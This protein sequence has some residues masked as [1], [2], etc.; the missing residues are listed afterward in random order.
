MILHPAREKS[1]SSK[2]QS[3]QDT[4]V[5]KICV[6]TLLENKVIGGLASSDG[7]SF[8]AFQGVGSSKHSS[9]HIRPIGQ[10]MK[11]LLCTE[12]AEAV[13]CA[14]LVVSTLVNKAHR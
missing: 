8:L 14:S 2:V 7:C 3:V 1:T 12:P 11:K 10:S 5:S 6:I 9:D 4:D 13:I